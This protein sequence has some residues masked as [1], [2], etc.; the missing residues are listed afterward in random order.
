MMNL[1]QTVKA[2]YLAGKGAT[3]EEIAEEIEYGSTDEIRRTLGTFGAFL[4]N[5]PFGSRD[6]NVIVTKVQ[7]GNL[8]KAASA[9]GLVGSRK[10]EALLERLI[11]TLANDPTLI[12]NVL[13]DR[14]KTIGAADDVDA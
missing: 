12:D 10:H 5:K 2:A 4:A 9:R 3:A 6:V 13:D 1:A 11:R 8:Q 14:A 7:Y